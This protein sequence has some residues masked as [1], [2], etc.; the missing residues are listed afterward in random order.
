M[1]C[2]LNFTL[3]FTSYT[4]WFPPLQRRLHR[5]QSLK[6]NQTSSIS[7]GSA[8]SNLPAS[9][10]SNQITDRSVEGASAEEA[11]Q[12]LRLVKE[13]CRKGF[14]LLHQWHQTDL[15][16][17]LQPSQIA[18]GVLVELGRGRPH[19]DVEAFVRD[20]LCSC[21]PIQP[22]ADRYRRRRRGSDDQDYDDYDED[23]EEE[24]GD[25]T[26]EGADYDKRE[27]RNSD[28]M[29][30][31]SR[32]KQSRTGQACEKTTKSSPS[33]KGQPSTGSVSLDKA[34]PEGIFLREREL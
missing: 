5:E 11:E 34:S 30:S 24:V 23:E 4:F 27:G 17:M 19:L 18:L 21:D 13:L 32:K 1:N 2:L 7:I 29:G 33:T 12:T 8:S 10:A 14:E 26:R 3:S 15:C 28:S 31:V 6:G 25:K 20:E 16:L 22:E 9:R